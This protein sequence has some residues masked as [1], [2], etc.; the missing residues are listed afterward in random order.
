MTPSS[1]QALSF[2]AVADQYAASRPGYPTELFDAVEELTGR[3]LAGAD[4]VDVGAGTGIATALLR[5]RGARV[6]AAE[7]TTGMAA[8]LRAAQPDVPVVRADG[9]ALPFR[10]ASADLVT[11]AQAWHWTDPARSVPE[12][13][14]VLRPGGALALW[15]NV[16]D[17]AHQWV[18]E[19]ERRLTER[20][21]TYRPSGFP[22]TVPG[23]LAPFGLRIA[24]RS[25]RWSRRIT[26]DQ[27]L[28]CL[29]SH[30]FIAMLGDDGAAEIL[31]D[32]RAVLLAEFP[33]G[34]LDEPYVLQL[35][36]ARR[37][38]AAVAD[39]AG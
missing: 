17:L 28:E 23:L 14:R 39:T 24:T 27:H 7:P 34:M 32:E 15:W 29:S 16:P 18:A 25:V 35:V 20:C 4:V 9:N 1:A 30:S 8:G 12:A 13:L 2:D 6:T 38:R 22:D 21:A 11:Y 3:P 33:D 5:E 36:V 31:R 37:P 19:Q 10:D 26:I